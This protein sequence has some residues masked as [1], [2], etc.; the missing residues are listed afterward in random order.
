MKTQ[1]Q[2]CPA[3]QGRRILSS[4]SGQAQVCPLCQGKGTVQPEPL[5]V[6]FDYTVDVVVPLNGQGSA[7]LQINQDADFEW[8]WIVST[9][10]NAALTVVVTDNGTGRKLMS[11]P[12]NIANFAGTA[13]LPFP[14]VEP[15]ILPRSTSYL[16]QFQDS[17]GAQNTVEVVLRGYKLFPQDEHEQQV[18]AT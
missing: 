9:Q 2:V 18:A 8:I 16:F 4:S 5:R 15:F 13:Q 17:S 11:N 3:C 7:T 14:L 12:I 6:P 1:S 10:T